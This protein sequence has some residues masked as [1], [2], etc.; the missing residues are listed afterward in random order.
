MDSNYRALITLTIIYLILTIVGRS[1]AFIYRSDKEAALYRNTIR[2]LKAKFSSDHRFVFFIRCQY[3]ISR[4]IKN[5]YMSHV[6]P[7]VRRMF[8]VSFHRRL[9]P[10][11]SHYRRK[12]KFT[13]GIFR[14]SIMNFD[15]DES[16]FFPFSRIV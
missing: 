4:V 11:F 1:S 7:P 3:P 8:S 16:V 2:V 15:G 5:Y 9:F 14:A 6:F 10:I 12:A 13:R